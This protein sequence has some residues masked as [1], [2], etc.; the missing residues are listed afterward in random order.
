MALFGKIL[1]NE[2]DEEF[3][4]VHNEVKDALS[5]ILKSTLKR[6]YKLRPEAEIAY[7]QSEIQS[8]DIDE[9]AWMSIINKIYTEEHVEIVAQRVRERIGD[10]RL[11]GSKSEERKLTRE[12]LAALQAKRETKLPYAEFQKVLGASICFCVD[13]T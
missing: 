7:T 4:L 9:W 1:R 11:A 13:H 5:E 3:R 6:K 10:L 8:G 2:C 12:E